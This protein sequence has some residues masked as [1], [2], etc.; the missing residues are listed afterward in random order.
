MNLYSASN[1]GVPP[2]SVP[3]KRQF[4]MSSS[5]KAV[6]CCILFFCWR[7]QLR[8]CLRSSGTPR[9]SWSNYHAQSMILKSTPTFHRWRIVSV[10]AAYYTSM[11]SS[12]ASSSVLCCIMLY[13]TSV[14]RLCNVCPWLLSMHLFLQLPLCCA[15]LTLSANVCI[16]FLY[17]TPSFPL[18]FWFLFLEIRQCGYKFQGR[19]D[20]TDRID[21]DKYSAK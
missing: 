8:W 3:C 10:D 9:Y 19:F 5:R 7:E 12:S 14:M 2:W 21:L 4:I 18:P 13:Y 17:L 15:C 6:H 1:E 20:Y 11:L 16:W